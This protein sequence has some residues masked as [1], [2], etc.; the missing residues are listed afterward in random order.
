MLLCKINPY[1]KNKYDN[2]SN[3]P[4]KIT[5]NLAQLIYFIIYKQFFSFNK[6]ICTKFILEIQGNLKKKKTS[7]TENKINLYLEI[8]LS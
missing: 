5:I 7:I 3:S 6:E 8:N 2:L 4:Q 1:T